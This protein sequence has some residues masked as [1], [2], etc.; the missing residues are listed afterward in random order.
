[1]L[2]PSTITV[3]FPETSRGVKVRVKWALY[4]GGGDERWR[5]RR[6]RRRRRRSRSAMVYA[7][8][9]WYDR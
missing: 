5:R 1:M 8:V 3:R 7:N 6:R 4:Y 9:L 2:T